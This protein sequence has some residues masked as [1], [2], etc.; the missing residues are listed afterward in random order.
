MNNSK[1]T[2]KKVDKKF[3][4]IDDFITFDL[5]EII[6]ETSEIKNIC[7]SGS[8]LSELDKVKIMGVDSV[9]ISKKDDNL[10]NDYIN[11]HML[12]IIRDTDI[13]VVEKSQL[14]YS[15]AVE[16]ME[17]IFNNMDDSTVNESVIPLVGVL[18]ELIISEQ[19]AISSLLKITNHDYYTHTHS[20]N[21]SIY[22]ISLAIH[23]GY[24]GKALE[25]LAISAVLHD[26]GKSKV[27]YDIINKPG[28]LDDSEFDEMKKHP[29]LGYE[30]AQTF[31]ITDEEILSGIRDHHEKLSGGGYPRG[32]KGA[33]IS[34]IARII[35]VCDVF[36][37]LSTRRS[38]KDPM[39]TY[40][41][42]MLIKEQMYDHLDMNIL[43]S[44]IQMMGKKEIL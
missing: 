22:A 10:Y 23:M 5:Y 35:A 13:P 24:V 31:N 1:R 3:F 21:V 9:W 12:S 37:A 17:K 6:K 38:Y 41:A 27:N 44:F 2:F 36:D 19:K 39:T 15:K 43:K 16:A 29:Q 4:T 40:S 33:E 26:L 34:E 8:K 42:F 20:I 14:V 7:K 11:K 18:I 32:L 25:K 28:K 30:L